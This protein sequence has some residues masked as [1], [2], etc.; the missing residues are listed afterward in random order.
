MED[1]SWTSGDVL[2]FSGRERISRLIRSATCSRYTRI[3]VV[4]HVRRNDSEFSRLLSLG[5]RQW[6]ETGGGAT[7]SF[8]A[9][10]WLTPAALAPARRKCRD[11]MRTDS[12]S[13]AGNVFAAIPMF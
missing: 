10:L 7:S 5:V 9:L 1:H 12:C 3:A 11:R 2:A 4:D 8:R 6:W 13:A